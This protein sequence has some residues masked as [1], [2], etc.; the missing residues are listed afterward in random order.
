V[1]AVAP[2]EIRVLGDLAVLRDGEP[3]RLPPSKKTRALLAFLAVSDRP[4]RRERLC[5]MF[6]E[7]PDD[8]RGALRWSLSKL[9]QIVNTPGCERLEADRNAVFMRKEGIALDFAAVGGLANADLAACELAELEQVAARFRGLFLDDLALPRCPEFEAWRAAHVNEMELFRLKLLRQLI[10]RLHEEPERALP[11]AHALLALLPEDAELATEASRL[12]EAARHR[13]AVAA[14]APD[15]ASALAPEPAVAVA[16]DGPAERSPAELH[17]L[18]GLAGPAAESH[19]VERPPVSLPVRSPQ[20][21]RFC[22][23][24]DGVRIAYAVTGSGPPIVRAAHWMSHLQFDWESPVFRHW[25]AGLSDGHTLVRYDE[26][27]N[28]LSDWDVDDLS[29]EA[30][31]ADLESIVDAAGLER[32]TLLGV[33]QGCAISVAYAVRHPERVSGLVLYGGYVKGWRKR[34]DPAE[35]AQREAMATLARQGWGQDNPVFRQ[36]FTNLFIPGANQEQMAWF[37]ELQRRTVSPENAYRLLNAFADIDVSDLLPQVRAPA[38][39]MHAHRDGVAPFEAGRSFAAGIPG[40]RFVEL[41]SAN[42]ILLE[43]EPAFALFLDELRRFV[44]EASA[45]IAVPLSADQMR[46]P[47]S[48]LALELISPLQA[49]EAED[50]E[51]AVELLDPLMNAASDAVR[52]H[53]GEIASVSDATLSAVFGARKATEDHALQACRAALDIRATIDR[54]SQGQARVRIALDTGQAIVRPART[55][56][57]DGVEVLGPPL[58]TAGQLMRS[59]RQPQ[60]AVTSRMR[61]AAGGYVRFGRLSPTDLMGFG[62]EDRLYE[63]LGENKALSRWYLRANQGLTRLVGRA[64][65]MRLIEEAWQRVREGQG[66]LIGL[67]GEPG[68]GKSR[69]THEFLASDALRGFTILE[70]GALRFERNVSLALVKKLLR[71]LCGIDDSDGT[72]AAL[73]KVRRRLDAVGLDP[74]LW[75]PLLAALDLP[76][77]DPEWAAASG[78]DRAK[79]IREAVRAA[80]ATEARRRPVVV[81][82]EDLHWM[83]AESEAVIDRLV[84]GL[85]AQRMLVL[86]SYRPEYRHQWMQRSYFQQVRL[87]RLSQGESRELLRTL[88][89]D[90]PSVD[91]LVALLAERTD[92]TPLFMEEIVRGLAQ[93]GRLTGSPGRYRANR[94]I[95]EFDLPTSVQSV[96]AARIERLADSDRQLL[97][98]AAVIGKDV[99]FELLRAVTGIP[100]EDLQAA[101]VRL[102]EAEFLFE[103]QSFPEVEYT[104]KHALT[105][106]VAYASL[107]S[108]TR[109]RL[110]GAALAAMEQLHAGRLA[111]HA[112]KLADHALHAELWDKAVGYLVQAAERAEDRSAHASSI[113]YLEAAADALERLPETPETVLKAIHVRTSMRPAYDATGDYAK[114]LARLDE[115]RLLAERSGGEEALATVLLHHSYLKSTYGRLDEALADAERLKEIAIARGLDRLA[116][117]ADLAAAKVMLGRCEAR[118]A[119]ER[120]RPHHAKYIGAWRHDRFG[121]AFTR[122][123]F[124]LCSLAV[125]EAFLGN[126]A[127]AWAEIDQA[128][129]IAQETRRSVDA[130]GVCYFSGIVSILHGPGADAVAELESAAEQCRDALMSFR[131]WFLTALGHAQFTRGDFADACETLK[132]AMQWAERLQMPQFRLYAFCILACACLAGGGGLSKSDADPAEA[133][134]AARAGGDVWLELILVR[135]MG[136]AAGPEAGADLIRQSIAIAESSGFPGEA[137]RGRLALGRLLARCDAGEAR[138]LIGEASQAMR[139]LGMEQESLAADQELA[140]LAAGAAGVSDRPAA[141]RRAAPERARR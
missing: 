110:H 109:K 85:A 52:R 21:I 51:I 135:T 74:R 105:Q 130:L 86:T 54:A 39:V 106:E 24:R 118:A 126:F 96:I 47:V 61:D 5:E 91:G 1:K 119:A 136:A 90:N 124:Y 71:S 10:D 111:E 73:T 127:E 4:Q 107:L 93:S 87:D 13:V 50:P 60:V 8:P 84:E 114:A 2:V 12:A 134:A 116:S 49:F 41:E 28:G 67:V 48:V 108:D 138:R 3:V 98:V 6:W 104:F 16:P 120:L 27:G 34:S 117:E 92:G 68:I 94:A 31:I 59:L 82:L 113:G 46:K 25:I 125:A 42:H 26:R 33:S 140:A 22:T 20:E 129:I 19:P 17:A 123:V 44:A 29:F 30:M 83:D 77:D 75:P 115:A 66:Q 78:A 132:E 14:P 11:Y 137:A 35:A 103:T 45:Q 65:E 99:P 36:L 23:T 131:P 81:L 139:R 88:L 102:Q 53:G 95:A 80:L 72:E 89:G 32:F 56:A 18:A 63:I 69:V 58:R 9:R 100:A 112:E 101:L 38:L 133:L 122:S 43:H 64:T 62:R 15:P 7:I 37:N 55:G 70:S 40:A 121:Q 128:R 79:A 76:V 97:Q 57:G 141:A